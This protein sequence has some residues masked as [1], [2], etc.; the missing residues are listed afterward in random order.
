VIQSLTPTSWPTRAS[1]SVMWSKVFMGFF[2]W[3]MNG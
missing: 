2:R 3:W 1:R